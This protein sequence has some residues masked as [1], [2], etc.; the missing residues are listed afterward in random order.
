[1]KNP[2]STALTEE[3][4]LKNSPKRT[5]AKQIFLGI[6]AHLRSYEVAIKRDNGVIYAAQRFGLSELIALLQAIAVAEEVYAVYEAGPLGYSLY[7]QIKAAGA[8]GLRQRAG[9]FGAG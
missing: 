8:Q 4:S 5:K 9:M 6:D 2:P 7:R 1:M 3:V